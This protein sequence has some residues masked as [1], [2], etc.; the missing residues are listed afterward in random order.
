MNGIRMFGAV[1]LV[2]GLLAFVIPIPETKDHSVKVGDAK[3]GVQTESSHKL[4]TPVGAILLLGGVV[5][6]AVGSKNP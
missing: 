4:P 3:I 2:L 6:L 5:A 1:L